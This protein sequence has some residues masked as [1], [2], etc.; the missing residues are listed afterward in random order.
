KLRWSTRFNFSRNI[1]KILNLGAVS[2]QYT[3]NVSSSLFPSGGQNSSILQ[4]G[5]PIGSFFGYVFNGIWQS[6]SDITKS[7]TKQAVKPGDP[8]YL[9]MNG[10]SA[11][12]TADK[13]IIGHA[14]PKFTY[15]FTSDF[16]YG[17]FSLFVLVQGVYGVNILNENKIESENGSTAD[18]KFAY[19]ATESWTGPGTS[20]RLPSVASTYRRGLGVTSD[21]IEDGSYARIKTITLSYALPLPKLA[22]AFKSASIYI[23]GQNLITFT[24]YSG[25]DPEV[26]SYSNTSGNYTSLNTDYNP[27][28]NVK[29]YMAGIKLGF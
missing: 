24:H 10:D 4:V 18:N 27:Y 9:D 8:I 1:N 3:G 26:N 12:T 25:Y 29:T 21:I 13:R 17:P 7:G 6:T 28:P 16:S 19:V 23:T 15:G 20:N 22:R 14:L 11:L 2:Y 5:Q